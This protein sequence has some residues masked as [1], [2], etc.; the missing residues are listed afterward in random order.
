MVLEPGPQAERGV[1]GYIEAFDR[2]RRHHCVNGQ[3]S[4]AEYERRQALTATQ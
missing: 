2:P 1:F 4:C 3:L